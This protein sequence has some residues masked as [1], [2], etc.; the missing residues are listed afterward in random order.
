MRA[1]ATMPASSSRTSFTPITASGPG[2]AKFDGLL[3]EGALAGRKTY[4]LKP[5]TY[6]NHSGDSVG[7]GAALLQA[8]AGGAG[9]DA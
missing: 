1:T 7:A 3:S 6:M 4:L 2:S 5:Q 8:A 9:G